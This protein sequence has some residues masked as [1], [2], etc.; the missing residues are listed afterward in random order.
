MKESTQ[1]V[2][3]YVDKMTKILKMTH[4]EWDEDDIERIVRRIVKDNIK[5]PKVTLDNNY[6]KE[7]RDTNLISVLNWC[8]DSK[9]LIAGNATFYQQ[10]KDAKNPVIEMLRGF[11]K[12]R[13]ENKKKMFAAEGG[14][15]SSEYA[16]FDRC[17]KNDKINN[18]SWY[19]ATGQP[20]S[21]FYSLWSGPA[22]THTARQAIS[23]TE[24]MFEAFMADNFFFLDITECVEWLEYNLRDIEPDD[25]DDFILLKTLEETTD[26]ICSKIINKG[27]RDKEIVSN[28][29]YNCDPRIVAYIFYKNNLIRFIDDHE[30]IQDLILM[31]YSNVLNLDYNTEDNW[32]DDIPGEYRKK[33][34]GKEYD[35]WKS[36]VDKKYFMDPNDVPDE[37]K[38]FLDDLTDYIIKY[39][40]TSFVPV[41]RIYR[42]QNFK[43][44]CVTVIDT[45]SNILSLDTIINFMFDE[46]IKDN[47]FNR[48]HKKN[49]YIAVNT[50]A[51][52][53]TAAV[54]DTLLLYGEYSNVEESIRPVYNMKNE[55]FFSKLIIG[56]SKKRYLSRVELREGNYQDPPVYDVKGFDFAK[57]TTSEYA[58]KVYMNI[59]KNKILSDEGASLQDL[60]KDIDTFKKEIIDSI[61]SGDTK[62]LPNGSAKDI[63]AYANPQSQGVVK[64]VL[65]WDYLNPDDK[66]VVPNKVSLLKLNIFTEEDIEPLKTSHPHVYK[67]IKDKIFEDTTGIFVQGKYDPGIGY[68]NTKN[69]D[70]VSEIPKKYQT[71]YRKLGPK[72]WNEFVDTIDLDAPTTY[73]GEWKYKKSGLQILAIP[74]G[75]K[76]PDW[77]MPYIDI[78]TIVNNIIAPFIPVLEAYQ[79]KAIEEGKSKNGITRKSKRASNIVKF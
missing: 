70:W 50:L 66:I 2:D 26:R 71:K 28:I 79:S 55:F 73:K 54:T 10:H 7:T 44:R 60:L 75:S 39:V 8:N 41:D 67:V 1:Y 68:V 40:Y 58:E 69:K 38:P 56:K 24:Q 53:I 48:D 43:R 45:D 35:D 4:P 13:K 76:I 23:T 34:I 19:G 65:T 25:V 15:G 74:R 5:N 62:F 21:A 18:N 46:V 42:L 77:C 9:P 3:I 52:I 64:G 63:R 29:L 61:H 16:Y 6:R 36:F 11:K 27:K 49:I 12:S 51:Y 31:I 59:I 17:Q 30:C 32:F 33:F 57:S 47:T 22:T 78:S 20:S 14:P 37:I 72:A